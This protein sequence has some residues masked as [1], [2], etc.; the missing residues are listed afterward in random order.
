MRAPLFA[1][2]LLL[3]ISLLAGCST[4]QSACS[5]MLV[6][7]VS[8]ATATADHM[9]VAPGDE[10]QFMAT[11]SPAAQAG[12]AVPAVSSAASP[13]IIARLTPQWTVSDAVNVKIS[14]AAD[15]TNGL[16]TCIGTTKGPI[17]VTAVGSTSAGGV[18]ETLGTATI[19]C[20]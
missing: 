13:A 6:T 16:A 11:A 3:L 1:V 5:T 15:S 20:K 18:S 2:A 4:S 10:E 14:S 19:T 9:A 17:T 7:A 12:C 8:P